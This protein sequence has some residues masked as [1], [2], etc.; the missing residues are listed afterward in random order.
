MDFVFDVLESPLAGRVVEVVLPLVVL[1]M[2]VDTG[3]A[4]RRL[5]ALGT[6]IGL[7]PA[8]SSPN[9]V[10]RFFE[11]L[12]P[13]LAG[14]QDGMWVRLSARR[15]VSL[16]RGIT[17]VWRITIQVHGERDFLAT[18]AAPPRLIKDD[19]AV[20]G[21]ELRVFTIVP[22]DD[23]PRYVSAAVAHARAITPAPAACPSTPWEDSQH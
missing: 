17:M 14:V 12:E 5:R 3:R 10:A 13:T 23:I 6:A 20:D 9:P 21:R 22:M 4:I 19:V 11:T 7:P 2:V 15:D 8:P 16:T 18:L 1:V